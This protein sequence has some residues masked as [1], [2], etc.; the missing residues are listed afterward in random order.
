MGAGP[1]RTDAVCPGEPA[2]H[3]AGSGWRR[4]R[5]ALSPKQ[6]G[7]RTS[8]RATRSYARII[9][10]GFAIVK[11]YF[12]AAGGT[13]ATLTGWRM[14]RATPAMMEALASSSRP[15]K[16]SRPSVQPRKTATAGLTKA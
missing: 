7:W 5:A 2:A 14:M 4:Q 13:G 9:A 15:V 10:Y 3:P 6:E 12:G 11:H 16:G 1:E 8:E